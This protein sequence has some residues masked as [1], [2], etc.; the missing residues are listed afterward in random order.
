MQCQFVSTRYNVRCT[1]ISKRLPLESLAFLLRKHF[2]HLHFYQSGSILSN[3]Y[4]VSIMFLVRIHIEYFFIHFQL[5]LETKWKLTFIYFSF[6]SHWKVKGLKSKFHPAV[7]LFP[8]SN[9]A[10]FTY[11]LL[12][13]MKVSIHTKQHL[14][15]HT[16]IPQVFSPLVLHLT[17][18][19]G[20]FEQVNLYLRISS[21]VVKV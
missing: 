10:S 12:E 16:I 18:H 7:D 14:S 5:P 13:L 8:I 2:T 6:F 1:P 21:C 19:F 17:F 9:F 4:G 20:S 3:L 11:L 15:P